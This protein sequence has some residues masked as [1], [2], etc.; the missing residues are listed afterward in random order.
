MAPAYSFIVGLPDK[1][2]A[3]HY[4]PAY[5]TEDK[6]TYSDMFFY[7][8]L[9][10]NDLNDAVNIDRKEFKKQRTSLF[11]N[12]SKS[13]ID[14]RTLLLDK[15][16]ITEDL[17]KEI[18]NLYE[19]NYKIVSKAEIDKAIIE[20]QENVVIVKKIISVSRPIT[21]SSPNASVGVANRHDTQFTTTASNAVFFNSL[22]D[23]ERGKI[24]FLGRPSFKDEKL[25]VKDFGIIKKAMN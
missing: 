21:K 3:P 24:I 1:I 9:L 2:V 14:N 25:D 17:K 6:Y 20:K 11:T 8:T 16:L 13:F 7:L 22:Y 10:Q 15:A 19:Y 18:S 4:M 23:T 12:I 5:K